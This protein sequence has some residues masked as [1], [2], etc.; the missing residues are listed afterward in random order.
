MGDSVVRS[1]VRLVRSGRIGASGPSPASAAPPAART[2]DLGISAVRDWESLLGDGSV[3][4]LSLEVAE[5]SEAFAQAGNQA[6]ADDPETA[7][8][9]DAFID[10]YVAPVSV[11][12][13]GRSLLGDAGYE[14]LSA[15]L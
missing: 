1:A 14:R 13:I 15:R 2:V 6:A 11:P 9:T 12:T 10:L 3:R 4:R 5:V 8:P 7:N